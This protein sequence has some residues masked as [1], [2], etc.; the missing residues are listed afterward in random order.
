MARK[1]LI[2]VSSAKPTGELYARYVIDASKLSQC[3]RVE[4][5]LKHHRVNVRELTEG[6]Q[7]FAFDLR[8]ENFDVETRH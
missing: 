3:L 2:E 8:N 1:L 7:A 6:E 4:A 5:G